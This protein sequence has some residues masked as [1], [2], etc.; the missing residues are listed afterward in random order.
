MKYIFNQWYCAMHKIYYSGDMCPK[1]ANGQ[2]K[3]NGGGGYAG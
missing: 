1:C 2:D 3:C